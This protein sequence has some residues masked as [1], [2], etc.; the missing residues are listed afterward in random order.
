MVEIKLKF[1]AI[2]YIFSLISSMSTGTQ[3]GKTPIQPI[4]KSYVFRI[5][6]FSI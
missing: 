4:G 5:K 2:W 3:S 1:N 6:K